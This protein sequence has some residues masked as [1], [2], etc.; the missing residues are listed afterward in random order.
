MLEQQWTVVNALIQWK[1]S[2]ISMMMKKTMSNQVM[3]S[4]GM[5]QVMMKKTKMITMMVL[6][7]YF[8][9]HLSRKLKLEVVLERNQNQNTG[10]TKLKLIL[11]ILKMMMIKSVFLITSKIVKINRQPLRKLKR[12]K[13]LKMT[14]HLWSAMIKMVIKSKIWIIL[15][16]GQITLRNKTYSK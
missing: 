1:V 11:M 14:L 13:K 12:N 2:M 15:A 7:I 8:C 5:V 16:V 10:M 3:S 6:M 4:L 9:L